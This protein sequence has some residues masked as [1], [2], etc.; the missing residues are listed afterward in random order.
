MQ[1][2]LTAPPPSSALAALHALTH[3]RGGHDPV[4]EE[5]PVGARR[6]RA[7]R[8]ALARKD[9]LQRLRLVVRMGVCVGGGGVLGV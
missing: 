4:P 9:G 6:K 5:A 8:G 7:A 1:R 2:L 3:Q